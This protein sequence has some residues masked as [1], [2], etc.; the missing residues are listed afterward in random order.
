M[1]TMCGS[2]SVIALCATS[3]WTRT[4]T[5]TTTTTANVNATAN[6]SVSMPIRMPRCVSE[7]RS[8]KVVSSPHHNWHLVHA[9]NSCTQPNIG[10]NSILK[11][12]RIMSL[13]SS[14]V[15]SL[16][17]NA[18]DNERVSS[19]RRCSSQTTLNMYIKA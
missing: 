4:K 7:M 19:I 14:A 16:H 15:R 3:R 18:C 12:R 10:R 2:G 13:Y 6:T 11:R 17:T 5:T 1:H 8:R 9:R